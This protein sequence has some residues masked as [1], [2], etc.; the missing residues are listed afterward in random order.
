MRGSSSGTKSSTSAS[1]KKP[2]LDRSMNLKL[3]SWGILNLTHDPPKEP[4]AQCKQ[5]ATRAEPSSNDTNSNTNSPY[6]STN[7]STTQYSSSSRP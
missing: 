2:F 4:M 7:K 1:T 3:H 6:S 5:P